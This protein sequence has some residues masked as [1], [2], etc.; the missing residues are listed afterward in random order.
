MSDTAVV[1]LKGEEVSLAANTPSNISLQTIIRVLPSEKTKI[2]LKNIDGDVLGS[3][4]L[5]AAN[6]AVFKKAPT[7][8]IEAGAPILCTS[9][10]YS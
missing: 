9:V 1:K 10:A 3:I 5:E 6:S 2:I 7:D 4:T 8:T